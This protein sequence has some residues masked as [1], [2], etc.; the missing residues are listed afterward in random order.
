MMMNGVETISIQTYYAMEIWKRLKE[1]FSEL[2]DSRWV[3]G[4][5]HIDTQQTTPTTNSHGACP[6]MVTRPVQVLQTTSMLNWMATSITTRRSQ[7]EL[8]DMS[9]PKI[10][11]MTPI[12]S[13]SSWL[14]DCRLLIV[15]TKEEKRR[16]N[17]WFR[18][19]FSRF[20][21]AHG[22]NQNNFIRP[23]SSLSSMGG[24]A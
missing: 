20:S 5:P 3:T 16:N 23:Q 10:E 1:K 22:W 18:P 4:H 21:V 8:I 7:R 12:W 14:I 2:N 9:W 13:S 24:P 15:L 19:W 6:F 11:D 17:C